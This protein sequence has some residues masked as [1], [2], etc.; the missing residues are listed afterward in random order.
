VKGRFDVRK[1]LILAVVVGAAVIT[2]VSLANTG[3]GSTIQAQLP[4]EAKTL[5][6]HRMTT[7]QSKALG[8]KASARRSKFGL[9]YLFAEINVAPGETNGGAIRCP[10]KKWHPVSGLFGT[11]SNEVVTATD[12]PITMRRWAVFV[13]NEGNIQVPV[14]VGAVCE[15]GL[16]FPPPPA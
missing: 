6:A 12:A 9:V 8:V 5:D 7:A 1:F 13:R 4:G 3:S 10:G 16:R 2:A 14:V 11:D 15:K